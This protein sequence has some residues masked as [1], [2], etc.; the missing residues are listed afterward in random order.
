MMTDK[1]D[2]EAGPRLQQFLGNIPGERILLGFAMVSEWRWILKRYPSFASLFTGWCDLQELAS[3]TYQHQNSQL[4]KVPTYA[5]TV[6]LANC[7]KAM[8]FWGWGQDEHIHSAAGDSVKV[9]GLL[10]GL[11]HD[12]LLP[13]DAVVEARRSEMSVYCHLPKP[14]HKISVP[15]A[16]RHV[17]TARISTINGGRLSIRSPSELK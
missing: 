9:L 3:Q 6:G 7:L 14:Y 13:L 5:R 16:A 17:Y 1:T 2:E 8:G 11:L 4:D 10:A 12:L 15:N